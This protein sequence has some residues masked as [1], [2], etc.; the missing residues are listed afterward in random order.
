MDAPA[1]S[2]NGGG[3]SVSCGCFPPE[4]KPMR[5]SVSENTL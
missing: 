4:R 2:S 1:E 5:A 3:A